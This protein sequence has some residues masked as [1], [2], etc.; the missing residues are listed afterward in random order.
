[1]I[2]QAARCQTERSRPF[3]LTCSSVGRM[4]GIE[5]LGAPAVTEL[6]LGL[7]LVLLPCTGAQLT[8]LPPQ[9]AGCATAL[10]RPF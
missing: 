10:C 5:D 3:E 8:R 9:H 4:G 1:M 7:A 2:I 6:L